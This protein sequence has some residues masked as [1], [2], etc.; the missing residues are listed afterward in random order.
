[1]ET[2]RIEA[3][4]DGVFAIAMTLLVLEIHVPRLPPPVAGAALA[5]ALLALAPN[6]AGYAVSFIILGTLWIGH[7][8]HFHFIRRAD[9][10]LLWINVFYLACIAFLPFATA[11]LASYRDQPL[12][13]A[14]YGGTL[15]LA[16]AFLYAHWAY[17]TTG[18]R[19]VDPDL[20]DAAIA[21]AKRRIAS[22]FAVYVTATLLSLLSTA[23][24]LGLFAVM[25]LV[26]MLPG[27]VD[28]HLTRP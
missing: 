13:F 23:A 2:N 12:A 24:A 3:L 1:V 5:R 15:L 25:P 14:V 8:N 4:A 26:Y 22:G 21:A 6:V 17:A 10:T 7:H 11:L 18:R 20:S 27:R 19:L 16:G 9:R 28:R